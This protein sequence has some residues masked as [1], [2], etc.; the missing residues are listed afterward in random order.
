MKVKKIPEYILSTSK[1][2]NKIQDVKINT[3]TINYEIAENPLPSSL[4]ID[5]C[6]VLFLTSC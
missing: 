6:Y 2:G 5:K 4:N 1:N 3:G